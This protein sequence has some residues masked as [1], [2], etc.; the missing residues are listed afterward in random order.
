M[1]KFSLFFSKKNTRKTFLLL[2]TIVV[3]L[4]TSCSETTLPDEN[5]TVYNETSVDV[6][7]A[8]LDA[9][10]ADSGAYINVNFKISCPKN[11]Y[12]DEVLLGAYRYGIEIYKFPLLIK[13]NIEGLAGY[14]LRTK[15][16]QYYFE[17]QRQ[18]AESGDAT[19]AIYDMA[20]LL[21]NVW[22]ETQNNTS[23]FKRGF[24]S[25]VSGL[26]GDV[27]DFILIF[28]KPY[29]NFWGKVIMWPFYRFGY[30]S[31]NA[32]GAN[33]SIIWMA[34][35][36]LCCFLFPLPKKIKVYSRSTSKYDGPLEETKWA[37]IIYP[38]IVFLVIAAYFINKPCMENVFVLKDI[39]GSDT[40]LIP[41][42]LRTY[43]RGSSVWLIL[44]TLAAYAFNAFYSI[45]PNTMDDDMMTQHADRTGSKLGN[46]IGLLFVAS[47]VDRSIV[48]AFLLFQIVLL[49][50]KI[51]IWTNYLNRGATVRWIA[52]NP[53][54]YHW[55]L[56]GVFF[57]MTILLGICSPS[58]DSPIR[59]FPSLAQAP[60]YK[61][62]DINSNPQNNNTTTYS[63]NK[64]NTSNSSTHRATTARQSTK[65]TSNTPSTS[66]T[67]SSNRT[68]YSNNTRRTTSTATNSEEL[69]KVLNSIRKELDTTRG[70]SRAQSCAEYGDVEGLV[71]I[72]NLIKKAERLSPNNNEVRKYRRTFNNILSTNNIR[73]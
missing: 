18:Y 52:S 65:H 9:L 32:F 58:P 31:L 10:F 12:L 64:K 28:F 35:I 24:S 40:N 6:G 38:L 4:F 46:S 13:G 20:N 19:K 50:K 71:Y 55:I 45:D 70:K 22:Y 47:F 14:R 72:N 15:Y 53:S 30:M 37:L 34:V 48:I 68:T 49:S 61:S 23:K 51:I 54:K 5:V 3:L 36:M 43:P 25:E 16:N 42:Y 17:I 66:K 11:D 29:D 41:T 73:L 33:G 26:F 69:N 56:I 39:Y 27:V 62:P 1:S 63:S 7:K 57:S 8:S 44:F 67:T 21:R 2:L 60:I 59:T